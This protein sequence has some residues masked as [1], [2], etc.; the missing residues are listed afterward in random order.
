MLNVTNAR[1][2]KF[3]ISGCFSLLVAGLSLIM[4]IPS[5]HADITTGLVGYWPLSDGP[6]AATVSDGS[7]FGN[8]GVLTNF[9]DMTF[10]NMWTTSTDPTNA[11]A[12][13]LLFNTAGTA[14][15]T[16]FGTNTYVNI[17]DSPSLD[18]PSSHTQWTLSAW[19]NCSVAPSSEPANAGIICKGNLN[20]EAYALYMSGGNFTTIFHNAA[21]SGVETVNSTNTLA[22]GTWY[23]VTATVWVPRQSGS[24]AEALIYVNGSLVS[25]TNSNTYTTVYNTNL[26]VTIGCRANA[27]GVIS[28]PFEGT[29]DQVR[30]YDRALSA[31][32]VLQLYNTEANQLPPVITTQPV[33]ATVAQGNAFTN[34]VSAISPSTASYQWYTNGVAIGGATSSQLII[35]PAEPIW[36]S[37][38]Y[39]VVVANTFGSTTSA[40]VQLTVLPTIPE[41]VN[42][43]PMT[44]TNLTG[45]NY[46]YLYSGVSPRFSVST[47][48]AT[49]VSYYWF[50]NG[51]PVGG[52]NVSNFTWSHV[53]S[54]SISS[55]CI[56]S[57][58]S[59]TATSMVWTATVLADPTN[60]TG[61]LAPYPQSVLALN[62]I[63][64]WRMD[65]TNEDGPDDNNGNF[66]YIC[67]DY[68]SGNNGMYTNCFLGY[69]GYNP[70]SDPSDTSAQFGESDDLGADFGDSLAF[71]IQ[72]VNFAA[73]AGS[74]V[75]FTVEAW[76]QGFVQTSDAGIVSL[77][78]SGAEQ[79]NLDTGSDPGHNFRFF[80]RDAAGATHGVSSSVSPN[81]AP[82]GQGPWFHLA[83][84]V[85]EIQNSNV[86]FYINGQNVGSTTLAPG[87]GVLSSSRLM[88][89]GS[90]PGNAS[91][92]YNF[93]FLG[94]INDVAL[95]NYALSSNQIAGQ[96]A[97]A[98]NTPPFLTQ[99]PPTNVT[100]IVG[101]PLTIPVTAFGTPTLTYTWSDRNGHT[102]A[103]GSSSG[104]SINATF[105]TN[106]VPLFWNGG[107]LELS[108]NNS[109]GQTNVY[110]TFNVLSA[111]VITN[112]LPPQVTIAQGQS[113]TYTVGAIGAAPLHYQ[114]YAGASQILNQTNNTYTLIGSTAGAFNYLVIITNSLGSATSVVST[115]TVLPTPTNAYSANILALNPVGYWPMHELESPAPGDIETN[116]GSLGLLGNGYYI[117]WVA[118][119][120]IDHNFPGALANDPDTS[121]YFPWN[122][123]SN[124]G[125]MT[126]CLLIP[127]ASPLAVLNPPFT[128]ECWFWPTNT[129]SGDIWGQSGYEGL[130]AGSVGG[131][132]GNVCGIRVY[133]NAGNFTVY[134]YDNSSTLHGLGSSSTATKGEWHH[135]VVTCD[136]STNITEYL[137]GTEQFTNA[138]VGLYSPDYW[139]P[140]TL[141]TGRGFTRNI[142]GA[143]DEFA[144]YTTN[145]SASDIQTHYNDG[146]GG[147]PGVYVSDVTN[148]SPV[149]YLRMDSPAFTP[150]AAS[151]LPVLVNFGNSGMDGT[152][153]AGTAP[154]VLPGPALTNGTAFNGLAGTNVALFSGVSSFADAGYAAAYNPTGA[155]PVSVSAI[156]RGNPADGR[157][158]SIVGHSD[159]SWRLWMN[160]SGQ[161]VWQLGTNI[162]NLT[163]SK[164]YNDG[165]WHQAVG[166]YAPSANPAASGVA[167]LYVDGAVVATTVS[168]STNGIAPGSTSDVMIASD[169]QYTNTPSG[170]GEQFAGRVCDVAL[171]TNAL[172][173]GQIK[174]LY[175]LVTEVPGLTAAV[176]PS[177][178]TL[179]AGQSFTYNVQASG[180]LPL[181]YQWYNGASPILNATNSA[182]VAVAALGTTN[183][184]SC[185]VSNSYNGYSL[186]NVGPVALA[187]IAAPTNLYP[188]TVLSNSPIAYWRLDETTGT[189][190]NDYVGGHDALYNNVQQGVPGYNPT[191]DPDLA[192]L[193]GTIL[194]TNS[195]AGEIDN[196]ANGIANIDFSQPGGSNA[197]FSIEAWI[198][199]GAS[200]VSGAGIVTKGYGNG[201]EQFDL[202]TVGSGTPRFIV[203]DASGNVYG[204][205]SMM[206]LDGNWHHIAAVC[207]QAAGFLRLYIDGVD[208]TNSPIPS[209][210]GLLVTQTSSE[211]GANLLSI[212]ARTANK[213]ATSYSSQF[214]GTIDEVALY[215]YALSQSQ[216]AADYHAGAA[217]AVSLQATNL[218][219][220]VIGNQLSLSWPANHT[221]WTLQ[222][223]TNSLAVGISSNWVN[224]AGSTLTNQ[225][226][227]PIN[228]NNGSVF[229]RL[230]YP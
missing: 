13:A 179:Y 59:G 113:Y 157:N 194:P 66:G 37:I 151:V 61:G 138:A 108:V 77:G 125:G 38:T 57:N 82:L 222:A 177:N 148:D 129:G 210:V 228:F 58:A 220:S 97:S 135:V 88:A 167:S 39:D 19:V 114:W 28:S 62:P 120:G 18:L 93:Q 160:T 48:T 46:F 205:A 181:Y 49:P 223:Q 60:S 56:V 50:T 106:S 140:M 189:F 119:H 195:Y 35:N 154:G 225:M 33:S 127:Q 201:G 156:F 69:P 229:Y 86:T 76:V 146:T 23:N 26:P 71:G 43:F 206:S 126:N 144:E 75:A 9:A 91:T 165:N 68:A 168:A 96:Y 89:I 20:R 211:P 199:G 218:E 230:I 226:T 6:G 212:G 90:R 197:E 100:I 173:S 185:T 170:V 134:T 182:Y 153:T 74:N 64:Y 164:S 214:D 176:G 178:L 192:A 110:V 98:G 78:Y 83:A 133:W 118:L 122:G 2:M 42:Q 84:V 191:A 112:D 116:Y 174:N 207:D 79:F 203:R 142:P 99:L 11:D 121:A 217:A 25:G 162:S 183:S 8:T 166:V 3:K 54:G 80:F 143:I 67:H 55:Y 190:A 163:S 30:I 117:D 40:V 141:A 132:G 123:G 36:N 152:Y 221:G 72:N 158:Q 73:P 188:A 180:T 52:V 115:L 136:A 145:L 32:D 53:A 103:T 202:D 22:A 209:R 150:P 139:S 24:L 171:F 169:P 51:V 161:L 29:I 124:N 172:T 130:N 198:N 87:L 31:S 41:I 216:I 128:V 65:D 14:G 193:F 95:F 1:L 12:Y 81:P 219:F 7:G 44:Y 5:A 45:T 208:V 63:G 186:T 109:Y 92:N 131:G 15:S 200:Q 147:G 101:S 34:S 105:T 187:G 224:V 175:S 17:P 16:S 102:L 10:N 204:G 107:Q 94:D 215:N 111:P 47:L 159:N 104:T 155:M 149:I 4:G 196:S 85:D 137:D 227:I 27:S 21:G 184:Y 70:V 213:S